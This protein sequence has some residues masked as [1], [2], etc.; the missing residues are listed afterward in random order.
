MT[1]RLERVNSLVRRLAADFLQS[2][3]R[4]ENVLLSVMSAEV[5][6]DLKHA[7]IFVSVL[8]E[9]REKEIIALLKKQN[10]NFR[11]YLAKNLKMKYLPEPLFKIDQTEKTR[12]RIEKIL[13]NV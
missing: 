2:A 12:Q 1:R 11:S 10:K 6:K 5:S 4:I 9:T 7:K 13:K 3:F 8:P